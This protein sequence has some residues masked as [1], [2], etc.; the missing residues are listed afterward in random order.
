M[1]R[2]GRARRSLLGSIAVGERLQERDDIGNLDV[3]Q[4]RRAARLTV[5][6]RIDDIDVATEA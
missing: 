2:W 3:V 1:R 6:R 4:R 5:K